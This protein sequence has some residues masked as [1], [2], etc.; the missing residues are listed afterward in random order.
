[1]ILCQGITE[2]KDQYVT[3]LNEKLRK[4][5]RNKQEEAIIKMIIG[6]IKIYMNQEENE[7]VTTQHLIGMDLIFKG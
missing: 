6:D 3:K 7:Y 5:V 2:M 1:M 4:L